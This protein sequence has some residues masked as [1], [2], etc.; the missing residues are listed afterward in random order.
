MAMPI[1]TVRESMDRLRNVFKATEAEGVKAILQFAISGPESCNWVVEVAERSCSV[2]EGTHAAPTVTLRIPSEV[3]LAMARGE[4]S[5][6]DAFMNGEYQ[7]DGD[8]MFMMRFGKI[9]PLT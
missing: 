9:F 4:K 5:G 3:W 1:Q 2:R 7:V 8:I 6:R